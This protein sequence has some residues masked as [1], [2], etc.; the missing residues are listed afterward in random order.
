[1]RIGVGLDP[2]LGGR[3]QLLD[4][5]DELVDQTRLLGLRRLEPG[6]LGQHVHERVLDAEH[7]HGAGDAAATGQQAERHLGEADDQA[8]DVG[9]DAVVTRQ[10][11]LQA[12][13]ER[14]AVDRGHDRLAER[15]QCAQVAL[16]SLDRC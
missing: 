15:L 14:G 7:P 9:S 12:T 11:D 4:R 1:M 5:A 3:H 13:A 6:A 10:R 8:L 16:D 2:R